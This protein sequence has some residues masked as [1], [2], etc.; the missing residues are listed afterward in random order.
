MGNTM[1]RAT[2]CLALAI[3][4][5][6]LPAAATHSSLIKP[7][8]RNAIDSELPEWANGNAPYYWVP[9]LG[10]NGT[11]CA[12]RNGT[13]VCSPAQTCLWFSVGCTI[14]CKECDGGDQGP[15]NPNRKDRCGSGM[16]ATN[17]DPRTRTFNRDAP[18]GSDADWTKWNPWRAPGNAPVFDPCGRA[19]GSYKATPGKGEFTDTKYAKLGDLGSQVLPKYDTGTVWEAGST[20]ETMLSFRANHGGGYQYRLCPLESN[21]TE[22]CFQQTPMP[23]V[24]NS[25][26]M[27]S[28]GS[29]I[30][31]DSVDVTNGTL[32]VGGTWRMLGIPDVHGA[33]VGNWA[34]K[35][36]C[37]EP[38]YPDHPPSYAPYPDHQGNCTGDW[39][40]NLTM[41]D[42]L[43]VPE[44][45]TPGDYVLG[46]RWDCESTA[47]IWQSCADVKITAPK[48]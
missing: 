21:L 4:A 33:A 17:N 38:G 16:K 20:V 30:E 2:L 22:A 24:G 15:V 19:S 32:P 29:I 6:Y 27:I 47:Q 44:H 23:F 14:G 13:D 8:P 35:P 26:L 5:V 34:F 31:L 1:M 46:F 28:D 40:H 39:T 7:K 41:Y 37:Y 18:A 36:P 48:I 11:P 3:V 43:R 42:Y 9:S 12:C 10:K 25:K 45:L